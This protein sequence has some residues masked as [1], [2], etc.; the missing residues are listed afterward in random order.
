MGWI[1]I[2]IALPLSIL[3]TIVILKKIKE[4]EDEELV[5]TKKNLL[6]LAIMCIILC[7][8][9]GQGGFFYQSYDWQ[10]RNAI[11]RDLI[12]F[13]WPVYYEKIDAGF[14]YYMG[15]WMVPSLIG[16]IVA[17]FWGQTAAWN[18]A[19][20]ALLI[21]C[22]TG[23][24]L[25][26]LWLIKLLKIDKMNKIVIVF[27]LF[28]G[29]SGLDFVGVITTKYVLNSLHLE[30]W[31]V[32]YQFSSMIT[33]LFWVFNQSI[34]A[35]LVTIMFLNEKNVKN[36]MILI[37]LCLPYG[38][39]PFLGLIPLFG[40]RG[41]KFL[42]EEK[43]NNNLKR[44]IK[45]VFSLENCIGFIAI[46]PVYYM[47]YSGN[48]ATT[49]ESLR[50]VNGVLKFDGLKHLFLFWFLEIGIYGLVLLKDNRK[51]ELFWTALVSL[52]FIPMFKMGLQNDFSMRVS[53]PAIV[54]INYYFIK[55][56]LN[57][58][59]QE[60]IGITSIII[61]SIYALGLLTPVFEFSRAFTTVAVQ[62]KINLVA[63]EIVTFSNKRPDKFK[64]FICIHPQEKSLFYKYIS[65]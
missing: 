23:V 59:K 22:S 16:K 18:V 43:K 41:I 60:K 61:V 47:F 38:P 37:L 7:I 53:I 33:Q 45:Q 49:Q 57:I 4:T 6:I 12:N 9:S 21:W 55:K 13:D 14:V 10:W 27:L 2:T 46:L 29:F 62:G 51:D 8:L 44:F 42:I 50:L 32:K 1:K 65:K 17:A 3:L 64:N 39:F 63:D 25:T 24:L 52:I 54:I 19:N 40:I 11:Q 34:V 28:I 20:I 35:W 26:F 5:I 36:Y 15:T 48:E 56:Y 30:W 58:R 31:A